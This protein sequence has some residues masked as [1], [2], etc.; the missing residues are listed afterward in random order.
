MS[1]SDSPS[2]PDPREDAV[3]PPW[4]W[5]TLCTLS[6]ICLLF[7]SF[8]RAKSLELYERAKDYLRQ[9]LPFSSLHRGIHLSAQDLEAN[10]LPS[11]PRARRARPS[12]DDLSDSSSVHS[13]LDDDDDDDDELPRY[14]SSPLLSPGRGNSSSFPSRRAY[15][16]DTRPAA[17]LASSALA[18]LQRGT[19]ALGWGAERGVRAL[20]GEGDK[21]DGIARAFWGVRKADRTGGIRLGGAGEAGTLRREDA[22]AYEGADKAGTRESRGHLS[23]ASTS[24]AA[25]SALFDLGGDADPGDA[26]ELPNQ[27]SL[28]SQGTTPH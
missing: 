2:S 10:S 25:G 12:Q 15:T 21:S 13:V 1:D 20:R 6:L 23:T 11:R 18:A 28:S 19:D 9:R 27:F 4:I 8:R 22:A 26:V 3:L 17:S 14:T 16:L 24:S 5:L 7:V